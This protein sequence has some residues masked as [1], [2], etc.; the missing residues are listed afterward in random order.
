MGRPSQL[1]GCVH[2]SAKPAQRGR[3]R[4]C[5]GQASSAGA[6]PGKQC[7]R[8]STVE[9]SS[10]GALPGKQCRRNSTVEAAWQMQRQMN[11]G[12]TKGKAA[13]SPS[14]WNAHNRSNAC[15]CCSL[16]QTSTAPGA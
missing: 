12:N 13:D 15:L 9:A 8:N 11:R 6:L 1:R 16:Q 10:A 14:S 5:F 7:R 4:A 2:G 3:V